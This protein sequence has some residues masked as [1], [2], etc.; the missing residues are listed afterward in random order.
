MA[1]P[2]DLKILANDVLKFVLRISA[3]GQIAENV[4]YY[5]V[6][7][8]EPP[9]DLFD[10]LTGWLVQA[11]TLYAPAM[12]AAAIIRDAYLLIRRAGQW[13]QEYFVDPVNTAGTASGGLLPSQ[14]SGII[15]RRCDVR[16]NQNRGRVYVPFPAAVFL[17]AN[18]HPTLAYT[19]LLQDIAANLLPTDAPYVSPGGVLWD[20]GLFSK[21]D[22]T[23][24]PLL[25][26][27]EYD[28]WAT[29]RRRGDE[30]RKNT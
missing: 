11:S 13:S 21:K 30:G 20:P 6:E 15:T 19:S 8:G 16:T 9:A 17:N 28:V 1:Y 10:E 29:Q 14:T 5:E 22:N 3:L 24:R 23:F 27:Q 25:D 4:Y 2:L 18:E 7:A 12:P 26:T